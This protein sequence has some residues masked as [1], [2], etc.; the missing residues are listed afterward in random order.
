MISPLAK[1]LFSAALMQSGACVA[2]P[3]ARAQET[4]AAVARTVGCAD[5]KCLR[6]APLA[7]LMEAVPRQIDIS[8]FG[9]LSYDGVVDGTLV[10]AAPLDL[11]AQGKHH[12]VPFVVGSNSAETGNAVPAI[13]TVKDYEDRVT[14]L[15][16]A[17]LAPAVL[18][19]YP[20]SDHATPRAAYVALTSDAKFTC[21]ARKAA[22][23]VMSAQ[24]EP[25]YRYVFTHVAENAPAQLKALGAFHGS[26]LPYVFGNVA[27]GAYTPGPGDLAVVSALSG[28]WSRFA[29]S[30]DPGWTRYAATDPYMRIA[31]TP[32]M[33]SGYRTKQ[34]DFWDSLAP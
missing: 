8:A 29:A 19:Q 1:G 4:G 12:H 3:L 22:R 2:T 27:I 31:S 16:G 18:A 32:V 20:A 5:T 33:E 6:E 26:E 14:A 13:P 25:V 15:V 23:A 9:R 21:S 24:T 34:C 7:K 10:P 28:F 17:Q 30:G 11:I